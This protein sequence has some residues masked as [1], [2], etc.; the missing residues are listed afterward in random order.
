MRR[1]HGLEGCKRQ[2]TLLVPERAMK[3]FEFYFLKQDRSVSNFLIAVRSPRIH[4]TLHELRQ[5]SCTSAFRQ[6]VGSLLGRWST[7]DNHLTSHE[8]VN[9]SRQL[10]RPSL[11]ASN[12]ST[13][14]FCFGQSVV[15]NK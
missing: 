11:L 1:S 13:S 4:G 3:I 5:T 2:T 15:M 7:T 8:G 14:I 10:T 6:D 9:V 12:A